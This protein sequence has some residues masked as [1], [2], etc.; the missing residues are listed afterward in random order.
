VAARPAM[1]A[2][3]GAVRRWD[4][5][6]SSRVTAYIANSALTRERIGDYYGRDAT[7]VHPPVD[8][9]RFVGE[10]DPE[11]YFLVVGEVTGH[12]NTE[13]AVAAACRAG[14]KIT[15]VGDGPDLTRLRRHFPG[16]TF[17]G[18]VDDG[19]L[20]QLYAGC[21]ALI[22]PAIEEF[23]IT[24]VE[25]HAS[26]RPVIAADRG[27]AREIVAD[28]V[29]GVR[30]APG[31]V[32]ALAEALREVDWSAFDVA[33]LRAN[34]AR[35]SHAEFRRK[36]LDAVAGVLGREGFAGRQEPRGGRSDATVSGPSEGQSVP[37]LA[38]AV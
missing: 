33:R 25:A 29:T 16:A 35:F 26:G 31:N 10:P 17:L 34:A 13:V 30:F 12:K 24:M 4:L 14:V 1:R 5:R 22:V 37:G 7:V 21:R 2:V 3:L 19:R 9:D 6:A 11:D 15:V 38:A 28:D 36:L 23:G 32:D 8:V 18:R 27:G 20:R